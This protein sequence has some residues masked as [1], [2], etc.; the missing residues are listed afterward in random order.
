MSVVLGHRGRQ[1]PSRMS[2]PRACE[3]ERRCHLWESRRRLSRSEASDWPIQFCVQGEAL[4]RA[5]SP[6]SAECLRAITRKIAGSRLPTASA[7][8][9]RVSRSASGLMNVTRPAA[10]VTI[11]PSP[12]EASVAVNN[13]CACRRSASA[14]SRLSISLFMRPPARCIAST[15]AMIKRDAKKKA[16]KAAMSATLYTDN[17]LGRVHEE[18]LRRE[19]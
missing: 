6:R 16:L 18:P 1:E 5:G 7:L 19:R 17:V 11:T 14:I 15:A 9:Q 8:F 10:F 4:S 12:I 3:L 2:L 13:C